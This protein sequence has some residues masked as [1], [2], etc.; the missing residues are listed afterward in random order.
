MNSFL[1]HQINPFSPPVIALLP[2]CCLF[3]V[4]FTLAETSGAV[5]PPVPVIQTQKRVALFSKANPKPNVLR[6]ARDQ[7][8]KSELADVVKSNW[9]QLFCL[10]ASL[11]MTRLIEANKGRLMQG[12]NTSHE[13]SYVES[14]EGK[15]HRL[16]GRAGSGTGHRNKQRYN[17]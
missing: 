4:L 8:G 11:Q 5:F 3:S 13:A 2:L 17:K 14:I 9:C 6:S 7:R 16:A 1:W 10:G 12:R 15:K